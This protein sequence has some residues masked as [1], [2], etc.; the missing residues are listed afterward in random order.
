LVLSAFAIPPG[1]SAADW[2][3]WRGPTRDGI[4]TETG[5]THQ[6][7]AGGPK[8]LWKHGVGTGCSSFTAVG[9]RV[10]TM[11]NRDETDTVYCLEAATGKMVWKYSYAQPLDPNMFEGGP[12]STPAVDGPRVY[13]LSRHGRL[14]CL[15]DGKVVW[16]KHLVKDL[17]GEQPRWGYAESPLVLGD[18]LLL[19]PGGKGGSAMALNKLTGEVVWRA[20]DDPAAYA[21]PVVI[22]PGDNPEVAFLNA[23]GL[24]VRT[25]RE[26]RELWRH[27]WKTDYDVN[28]ASPLPVG[29][30]VFISSGYGHGSALLRPGAKGPQVTWQNKAL[31]N[32]MNSSVLWEG[33]VY[34]FDDDDGLACLEAATGTLKWRQGGLG[35]GSLILAGGRLVIMTDK[36]RLVVAATSPQKF[37]RLAEA[38]VLGPKRSWVVPTLAHGRIFCK[39]NVGDTVA[40][41]VRGK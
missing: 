33:H 24:V 3:Q 35:A 37:T 2:A 23:F 30:A 25:A 38:Q 28:A 31:R 10:Y 29:D 20:G 19:S 7:G 32:H 5:W 9:D 13:T 16:A 40:L 1:A 22:R 26:G 39:N 15:S 36:G 11:G 6:W 27:R 8:V 18:H 41:D 12:G 17:G 34:G 21:S 4:S 14:F